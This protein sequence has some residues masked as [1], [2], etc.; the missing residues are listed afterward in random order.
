M[1]FVIRL[2]MLV[3]LFVGFLNQGGPHF[4]FKEEG[5]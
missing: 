1:N 2:I 4:P 5:E 3:V